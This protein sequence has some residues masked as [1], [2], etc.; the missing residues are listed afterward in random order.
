V[1]AQYEPFARG[2]EAAEF[3]YTPFRW[4]VEHRFVAVRRPWRWRATKSNSVCSP[5]SA[6]LTTECW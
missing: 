6:T 4:N 2:W 5:S 1:A 3:T